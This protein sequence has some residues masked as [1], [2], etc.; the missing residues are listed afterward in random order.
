[1]IIEWGISKGCVLQR[2]S[3]DLCKVNLR[4]YTENKS[5]IAVTAISDSGEIIYTGI[6]DAVFDEYE[7][8]EKQY[9]Y[10]FTAKLR[11][12]PT[13][14]G[15]TVL[16]KNNAG[17]ISFSDVFVGDVYLLGGQ[18][19]MQGIGRMNG[20]LLPSE[21]V[22]AFY[23]NDVWNWAQDPLH[24]LHEAIDP[25]HE[26]IAGGSIEPMNPDVG[27]GP[28]V[29]FGQRLYELTGAP[30]GLIACAHGGTSMDQW[31]P[32]EKDLSGKSLYGAMLRRLHK[33]G[34]NAR[35]LFWYQGCSDT[36]EV[37]A[38]EYRAKMLNF[39]KSIRQDTGIDDLPIVAVQISRQCTSESNAHFW[40]TVQ[41][42]Q[43]MLEEEGEN[44]AV[45]PAIDLE[46]DDF[47]HISGT[48]QNRLG[49]RCADAMHYL[50]YKDTDNMPQIRLEKIEMID[51]KDNWNCKVV[52]TYK[53]V[54]GTLK[55]EG[56]PS[57]FKISKSPNKDDGNCIIRTDIDGNK[58]IL[59]T[60]DSSIDVGNWFLHYGLGFQPYCNITDEWDRSLPVIYSVPVGEKRNLSEP[61]TFAWLHTGQI[62]K[63]EYKDKNELITILNKKYEQRDFY[64]Y[65]LNV[66]NLADDMEKAIVYYAPFLMEKSGEINLLTGGNGKIKIFVDG[67]MVRMIQSDDDKIHPEQFSVPLYLSEGIHVLAAEYMPDKSG[68]K[69]IFL[70]FIGKSGSTLPKWIK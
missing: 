62:E 58:V 20:S 13:G 65:F 9:K 18:S 2:D 15:Y 6:I 10:K 63:L 57:G 40:N 12:I 61:C 46:M 16:F 25:A 51:C 38:D 26:I 39:I 17:E 31:S 68:A 35:G 60:T 19:N 56:R 66:Y 55:S 45:V 32:E 4:G 48:S 14:G 27:V 59:H 33:N 52:L 24:N 44:I 67:E 41:H 8:I 23:M 34:G 54:A 64:Y 29:A 42:S 47:I 36:H 28:G 7:S 69:G 43:Y 3:S 30:Q 5:E 11:G 21:K 22:R 50:N 49:K 70:R 53:N 37:V 1:M